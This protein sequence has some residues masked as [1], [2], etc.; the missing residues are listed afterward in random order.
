MRRMTKGLRA[1]GIA[2]VLVLAAAGCSGS[3]GEQEEEQQQSS[4]VG[5]AD[6]EPMTFAMI[7][8]A[9]PGDTFFDIIKAGMDDAATK[10]NV[11]VNYSADDDPSQQAVLVE[12]AIN[13]EVDG[14]AVSMPNADAL[15]GALQR[16]EDAGIPVVAFNAGFDSWEDVGA[17]MYFGQ[18]EVLAGTA[19]GERLNESDAQEVL[20]V[21]Q[22]QG[23]A[24]LEARCDG[25]EEAF[26]GQTSKLYVNGVDMSSVRSSISSKLRQDPSIDHVVMLGAPFA[27]AAVQAVEEANSEATVVTFDTNAQLVDSIQSGDVE[28]AVDQ[29]P[30]MQ[31]YMAI[32]GLWFYK[33]NGNVLGGGEAVLT[34]PAFVTQ[35][36][37]DE[38]VEY[39]KRG[40]R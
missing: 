25:V 35:E 27:L 31:G 12:N 8:H 33:T 1:L 39:A 32:D 23:Q 37:V 15:S 7:T 24:Q 22:A 9:P 3:G 28:W 40:T 21:P 11:T 26:D 29:Q 16:A 2:T 18:D 34:G 36:N 17:K 19:A 10:D 13:A 6:T 14:I 20:C 30:Y 5:S 4:G 38:V